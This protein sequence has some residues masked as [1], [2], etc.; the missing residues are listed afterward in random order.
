M[1]TLSEKSYMIQPLAG[2]GNLPQQQT[3]HARPAR[4]NTVVGSGSSSSRTLSVYLSSFS[5]GRDTARAPSGSASSLPKSCN[6]FRT[7]CCTELM[8]L[9][10]AMLQDA[11]PGRDPVYTGHPVGAVQAGAQERPEQ[12]LCPAAYAPETPPFVGTRLV[13]QGELGRIWAWVRASHAP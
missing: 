13:E 5:V 11:S 8:R 10:E 2:V 9:G 3:V 12:T 6:G 7:R 4:P 1:K